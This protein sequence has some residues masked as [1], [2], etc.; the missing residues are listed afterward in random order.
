MTGRLSIRKGVI[1]A[2]PLLGMLVGILI[3]HNSRCSAPD[4]ND[5]HVVEL[6]KLASEMPVYEGCQKTGEK[7]VMKST[8]IY[9]S[10]SYRCSAKFPEVM[11]FYDRVLREKGFAQP[12]KDEPPGVLTGSYRRGDHEIAVQK[13]YS[14]PDQ[15][16]L[17]FM[18]NPQ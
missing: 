5:P 16:E 6:K 18:W 14:E 10:V 4:K 1:S 11:A 12:Q 13:L 15:F 2:I 3:F 9:Y 8:L 7:V 17:V